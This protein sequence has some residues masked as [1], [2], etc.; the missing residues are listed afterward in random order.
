MPNPSEAGDLEVCRNYV[1][2]LAR[3]AMKAS[4][5]AKVDESDIAQEVLAKAHQSMGQFRGHSRA[6]LLAWLREILKTKLCD[7]A[8][9]YH[10]SKRDIARERSI[11]SAV[12]HSSA[13]L[14]SS[15]VDAC[16]S[17]SAVAM[18]HELAVLL[19][20]ALEGLPA[21]QREAVELHYLVECTFSEVAER[22]GVNRNQA[23][24]LIRRGV[25]RM[26]KLSVSLGSG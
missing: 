12:E 14:E 10:R 9:T 3:Q 24:G 1:R 22:M 7:V 15:L 4:L 23:A 11:H 18:K 26:R 8:R 6:E 16:S 20:A 21:Q 2:V 5:R 25:E 13:R 19:S 17:P